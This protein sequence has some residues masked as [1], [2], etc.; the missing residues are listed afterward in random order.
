[1]ISYEL[2]Q[3]QGILVVRPGGALASA[4][5]ESLAREVDPFIERE[6]RLEGLMIEAESFPGWQDFGSLV[7][8]LRFV[9]EHHRHV[10]RVAAVGDSR[11]LSMLPR[12]AGR[13]VAA[14]IR[15]FDGSDRDAALEWLRE[16]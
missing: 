1:M 12:V 15:H 7:S 11:L 6:G 4:D 2:L 13:F 14:E 9:R 16:P 8:H 5:F 10:R 3:D